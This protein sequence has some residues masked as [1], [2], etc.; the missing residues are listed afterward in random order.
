M[1]KFE[2]YELD[3]RSNIYCSSCHGGGEMGQYLQ[4]V[5]I[6]SCNVGALGSPMEFVQSVG[7]GLSS[8]S[9]R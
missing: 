4:V 6:A 3:A 5:W 7:V 9:S 1:V 8:G 2:F